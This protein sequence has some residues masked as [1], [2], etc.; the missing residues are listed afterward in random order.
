[1]W[2]QTRDHNHARCTRAWKGTP[3]VGV[4]TPVQ[5]QSTFADAR[6]VSKYIGIFDIQWMPSVLRIT[7]YF[8]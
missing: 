2:D 4:D 8:L 5:V 7:Q 1:M 3:R 6:R